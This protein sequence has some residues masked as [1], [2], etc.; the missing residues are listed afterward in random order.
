MR[1]AKVMR[2][3]RK[4]YLEIDGLGAKIKKLRHDDGRS[5]GAIAAGADISVQHWYQIEKEKMD[6][7]EEVLLR[8]QNSLGI[9]FDV[10][11]RFKELAKNDSEA[12]I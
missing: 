6:V 8:I 5:L 3:V 12:S 9:D 4:I 1:I 10:E 7:S 11:R 2:I